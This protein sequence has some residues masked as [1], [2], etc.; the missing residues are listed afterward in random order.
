MKAQLSK[1][2]T[3]KILI[4][5]DGREIAAIVDGATIV[6]RADVELV[7][8]GFVRTTGYWP[9]L[10]G[11]MLEADVTSVAHEGVAIV[12]DTGLSPQQVSA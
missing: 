1:S 12:T 5:V 4:T 7:K 8:A 11:R 3:G 9:T 2:V 10:F 6:R